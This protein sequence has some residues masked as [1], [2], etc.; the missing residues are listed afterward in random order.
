MATK[1][2]PTEVP[3]FDPYEAYQV[4]SLNKRYQGESHGLR[5]LNGVALVHGLP[6]DAD[7]EEV[8]ER[9]ELL[10]WFLNVEPML[11]QIVIDPTDPNSGKEWIKIAGYEVVIDDGSTARPG[12]GRKEA[13]TAGG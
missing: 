2:T 3:A 7:S 13:V 12:K 9:L 6:L 8:E 1:Q 4:K 10:A 5:F 11:R